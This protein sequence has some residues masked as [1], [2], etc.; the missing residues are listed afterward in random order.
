MKTVS[1][2]FEYVYRKSSESRFFEVFHAHPQMEFT[3]VHEGNGNLIIDGKHYPI[4]AN[5][6]MIFQPFQLHR[7]QMDVGPGAPFVR[8]VMMF[9]P[10]LLKPYLPSFPIMES[11]FHEIINRNDGSP[12]YG[13]GGTELL[14]SLLKQFHDTMADLSEHAR[15]EEVHFFLL[16]FLRQLM[17][18][19]K[20]ADVNAIPET[21]RHSHW[22]EAVMQWIEERYSESFKLEQMAK[23]LHLSPYHLAHLFKKATGST[24]LEY[25][26][27]TRI[28]HA[29]ILLIQTELTI[30]EIGTRV[31]IPDPSYFCKIFREKM[32]STPHQYRLHVQKRIK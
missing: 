6:L 3:Y 16:S 13:F 31:G 18:L 17:P 11:F 9:E 21:R 7:I 14:V 10:S 5:S 12:L 1:D 29:S 25:A 32:G 2:R 4:V 15:K 26:R 19:W 8:T 28:R 20:K 22:A 27:A 24:I 23:D 30:P